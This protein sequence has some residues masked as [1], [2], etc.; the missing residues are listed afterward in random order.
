MHMLRN[1]RIRGGFVHIPYSSEQ[2]DR[3]A[4]A[5]ALA[6]ETVVRGLRIALRVA[7]ETHVDRKLAAGAEH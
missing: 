3:H 2:A 1:R 4:G 6:I 5:P 7:L